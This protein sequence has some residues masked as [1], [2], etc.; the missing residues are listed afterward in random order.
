MCKL[1]KKKLYLSSI[2]L[3]TIGFQ[4]CKESSINTAD[5]LQSKFSPENINQHDYEAEFDNLNKTLDQYHSID[6]ETVRRIVRKQTSEFVSNF[7]RG[8]NEE[9]EQFSGNLSDINLIVGITGSGKSTLFNYLNGFRLQCYE[10]LGVNKLKLVD[11]N[12]HASPIGGKGVSE[13]TVPKFIKS[14]T[15]KAC[16]VDCAGE[17]DNKK[18]LQSILNSG[19]K[20]T[21]TNRSKRVKLT[22]AVNY[23]DIITNRGLAFKQFLGEINN[24]VGDWESF[25]KSRSVSI[26]LTNFPR[27]NAKKGVE[28]MNEGIEGNMRLAVEAPGV[29]ENFKNLVEDVIFRKA[30]TVFFA[31]TDDEADDETIYKPYKKE[32]D[33]GSPKYI[34]EI[35]DKTAFLDRK[36]GDRIFCHHL[37]HRAQQIINSIYSDIVTEIKVL[38]LRNVIAGL[39]GSKSALENFEKSLAH[40]KSPIDI[41]TVAKVEN[42]VLAEY[43]ELYEHLEHFKKLSNAEKSDFE[44]QILSCKLEIVS[45]IKER[46][47]KISISEIN[48]LKAESIRQEERNK[49]LEKANNKKDEELKETQRKLEEERNKSGFLDGL[50][51]FLGAAGEAYMRS[52]SDGPMGG[53]GRGCFGRD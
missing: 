22:L 31:P 29:P 45:E 11:E 33:L 25:A 23:S 47:N 53:G 10:S 38:I 51:K 20:H 9:L 42:S 12:E 7:I 1:F 35:L 44:K 17:F 39:D 6:S 41:L 37:Q 26:V 43:E 52:K 19:F 3:L 24:F 40:V 8:F 15:S 48:S 36:E 4:S 32:M 21:L 46:I 49:E 34:A 2:L 50:S 18:I 16:Y 30:Y 13:T 27:R 14:P 5:F 28:K